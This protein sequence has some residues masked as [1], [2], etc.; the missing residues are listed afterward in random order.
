MSFLDRIADCNRF[1]L[2]GFRRFTV[3]GVRIGWIRRALVQRLA[4]FSDVFVAEADGL[5]LHPDLRGFDMR[6]AAMDRVVRML[7]AEG[8]VR[9]R[10][11]EFYPVAP[12]LNH[13][14]LF[15]LERAAVSVFGVSACGVHMTGFV[16]RPDGVWIWVPRRA[17]NKSTHPGML[18]NTVAGGQP[19]GLN[20][21]ENLIKECR[22]EAGIPAALAQHAVEVA[23]LRYCLEAET[24]LKPDVQYCFDLELP[25]EFVPVN[26]DGEMESFEL[27]PSARAMAVV[28]DTRD[29]KDNCNLVLIDFFLR[30]GLI[31]RAYPG[32]VEIERGLRRWTHDHPDF[33]QR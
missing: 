21:R 5:A 12:S 18:D 15:R 4:A 10:R 8:V 2:T 13:C 7:E 27:W 25:V 32:Y 22:E 9:G 11:D 26:T 23:C 1:D 30:H 17:R 33:S 14:A 16:R 19:M 24:G 3:E 6:S 28:R 29:F 31:D 20:L